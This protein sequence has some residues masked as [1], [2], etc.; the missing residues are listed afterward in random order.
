MCIERAVDN[1]VII[2][3]DFFHE[4]FSTYGMILVSDEQSENEK[5]C[6]GEAYW[7]FIN[8]CLEL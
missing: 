4:H 8:E 1:I 7:L 5:L 6:F 2:A 3:D